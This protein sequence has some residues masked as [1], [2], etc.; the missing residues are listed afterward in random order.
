MKNGWV[1]PP[2]LRRVCDFGGSTT[3]GLSYFLEREV[4]L[5]ASLKLR[6]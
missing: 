3:F 6:G 4:V 1:D 5:V 2:L